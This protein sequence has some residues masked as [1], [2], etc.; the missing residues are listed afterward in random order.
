MILTPVGTALRNPITGRE[1]RRRMRGWLPIAVICTSMALL[2]A[3]ALGFLVRHAGPPV[4]QT[5][6][7]GVQLFQALAAFQLILILLLTPAST[8]GAISGERQRETWDLLLVTRLSTFGIV[9]GKLVA[10]LAFNLVLI[11]A[12]LPI[13]GPAFILSGVGPDVILHVYVVYL[14]TVLLLGT[15]SLLVSALTR[16]PAVSTIVST[17]VALVLAVGLSLLA[18]SLDHWGTQQYS[19]PGP[20]GPQVL[21]LPP[22]NPLAQLDPLAALASALPGTSGG[23]YLGGLASV[24]HAFGLPVTM[25]LWSAYAILATGASF[26]ILVLTVRVARYAPGWTRR[27]VG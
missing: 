3:I 24:H 15:G 9:W 22:L 10:A 27:G 16:R 2:G 5:S 6:A 8:A 7:V 25:Q 11:V 17:A 18:A 12:S 23:S 1:L 21:P 13:F 4:G 14:A 19:L 20:A 26:F